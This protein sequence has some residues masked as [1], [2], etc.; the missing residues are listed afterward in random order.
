VAAVESVTIAINL[1]TLLGS[2]RIRVVV[3]EVV[4]VAEDT[5]VRHPVVDTPLRHRAVDI[6]PRPPGEAVAEAIRPHEEALAHGD[7][8]LLPFGVRAAAPH[9]RID[10]A[11]AAQFHTDV[12]VVTM[13]WC[14]PFHRFPL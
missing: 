1:V 6:L 12:E 2:A 7:E 5:L 8:A 14:R 10:P 4:E 3:V 9:R 11:L 13:G